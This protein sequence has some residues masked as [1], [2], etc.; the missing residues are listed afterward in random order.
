MLNAL[1][2]KPVRPLSP[3]VARHERLAPPSRT[4]RRGV[5]S[6]CQ[7]GRAGDLDRC[8]RRP[9]SSVSAARSR[10]AA[11]RSPAISSCSPSASRR[12]A[13]NA[14]WRWCRRRARTRASRDTAGI[15]T[16]PG[17]FP[18]CTPTPPMIT[19]YRRCTHRLNSPRFD[20][21]QSQPVVRV[22]SQ[23]ESTM[24]SNQTCV[25]PP[26]TTSSDPVMKDESSLARNRAAFAIS[27][28]SPKRRSGT[29]FTIAEADSLSCFSESP[30]LP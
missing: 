17:T 15:S 29:R 26:S 11:N 8:A 1:V 19:L 6:R 22:G 4:S 14:S 9:A 21:L 10:V 13:R 24:H 27:T 2:D 18:S 25:R 12:R 16:R 5:A 20:L 3:C 30:S 7:R 28:A 23:F